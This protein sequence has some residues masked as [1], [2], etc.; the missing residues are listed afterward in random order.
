MTLRSFLRYVL[1]VLVWAAVIFSLSTGAGGSTH[2]NSF[3]DTFLARYFPSLSHRLTWPERD[4]IHYYV[5]KAAHVTEYAVFG[6]LLV[7]ALRRERPRLA[8]RLLWLAWALATAYA[9]TD[10]FHQ[11]FVPGR[12]PKV[13]DVM[14]DSAGAALGICLITFVSRRRQAARTP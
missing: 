10:E 11:V 3:L 5:R 13:T 9:A 7:R 14:L 6:V 1:P 8:P 2:T 4:S 12:T